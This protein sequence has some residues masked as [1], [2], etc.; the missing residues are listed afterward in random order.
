[1]QARGN[2]RECGRGGLRTNSS[3]G[4]LPKGKRSGMLSAPRSMHPILKSLLLLAVTTT[5]T[6]CLVSPVKNSGGPGATTVQNSNP[7]TIFAVSREVFA[8]Y[9]YRPGPSN[10]PNSM[11]FDRAAG[12]AGELAFGSAMRS[13]DFRVQIQVLRIPGSNDFRLI[14]RVS[15]VNSAGRPGFERETQMLR[16]WSHQLR[17]L[18]REI[19]NRAKNAESPAS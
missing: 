5:L 18:M 12:T 14:P 6:G 17:P 2:A 15:R 10:F 11:T 8:R 4:G 3:A 1:M 7:T 13:T 9:G 19:R 16:T